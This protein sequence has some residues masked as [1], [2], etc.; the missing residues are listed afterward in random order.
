MTAAA[1]R[2]AADTSKDEEDEALVKMYKD[3]VHQ[4]VRYRRRVLGRRPE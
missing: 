1:A 3:H 2:P 4:F